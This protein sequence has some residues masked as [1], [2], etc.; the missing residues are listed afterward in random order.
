MK[1]INVIVGVSNQAGSAKKDKDRVTRA[2]RKSTDREKKHRQ[3]VR[4]A[5]LRKEEKVKRKEGKTYS[6]RHI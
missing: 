2:I 5:K 4:E 3:K 1:R 6:A